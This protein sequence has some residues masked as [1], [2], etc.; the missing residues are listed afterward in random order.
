LKAT[1]ILAPAADRSLLID[2]THKRWIV[3]SALVGATALAVYLT[4]DA[5]S[6][7][8]LTGGS[9]VGLW[10]GV[11]GSALMIYAGLLSALR[12]V[13]SWWWIG[14]RKVWLRGHI[15]LG[16]LS[17]VF[18]LC[19]S[20]FRWGGPIECLLWGA[21]IGVLATGVF[22]LL[23][24]QLLP[25]LMT[26]RVS[27]EAP[28]EQIPHLCRL[29]RK[30][31]DALVDSICGPLAGGAMDINSTK[32]AKQFAEDGKVQLRIFYEHDLRPFLDPQP[33]RSSPLFNPLQAEARFAKLRQLAGMD[34]CDE[35]LRQLA[36]LC[37]ERRA[38][39]DQER[40]HFWLHSWLL[41]HV[42]LSVALLVLGIAHVVRSLYY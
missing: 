41:L 28:Y 23:M 39:R 29:M 20:H 36:T 32:G 31:T 22:G 26:T 8:E 21:V 42:P 17:A 24:Q 19:H 12:R 15:W 18:L 35:Q 25:R 16:L 7:R 37:E 30:R 10:Y 2:S 33:P 40:I 14:S 1:R 6:L 3:A 9:T 38:W 11:V 13:P 34:E 27:A 4:F 5:L